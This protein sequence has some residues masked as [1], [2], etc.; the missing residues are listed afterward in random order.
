MLGLEGLS[1]LGHELGAESV[2]AFDDEPFGVN[3]RGGQ[4]QGC[5]NDK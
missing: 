2:G 1:Q 3:L 5:G 4:A